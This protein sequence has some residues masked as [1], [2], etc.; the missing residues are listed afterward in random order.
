MEEADLSA[1]TS[2]VTHTHAKTGVLHC[3]GRARTIK[4]GGTQLAATTSV[5]IGKGQAAAPFRASARILDPEI[6]MKSF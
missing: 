6:E 1:A 4:P 5:G 2:G 3:R